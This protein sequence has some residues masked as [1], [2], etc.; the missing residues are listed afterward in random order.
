MENVQRREMLELE[1]MAENNFMEKKA[2]E[3]VEQLGLEIAVEKLGVLAPKSRH[4]SDMLKIILNKYVKKPAPQVE[5]TKDNH[6][7][8]VT[9]MV[10]P[11]QLT[12]KQRY[13][14]LI[15]EVGLSFDTECDGHWNPVVQVLWSRGK[16]ELNDKK[17]LFPKEWMPFMRENV[18]M[19]KKIEFNMSIIDADKEKVVAIP[20][21]DDFYKQQREMIERIN[22]EKER[23]KSGFLALVKK[24]KNRIEITYDDIDKKVVIPNRFFKII[25]KQPGEWI[26]DVIDE[27]RNVIIAKPG[28]CTMPTEQN[29]NHHNK[30]EINGPQ[31][32][33]LSKP[34]NPF[35]HYNENQIN[36]RLCQ[37]YGTGSV[38]L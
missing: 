30:R 35:Y 23:K 15:E 19:H 4:A 13:T 27:D 38:Q 32:G 17:V 28:K 1:E 18:L 7:G 37:L 9:R 36:E 29:I 26:F 3:Y 2:D 20:D 6:A 24:N 12:P 14:N 8:Y 33:Q 22:E 31:N 11:E 10:R 34:E 21:M 5:E 16:A 25:K